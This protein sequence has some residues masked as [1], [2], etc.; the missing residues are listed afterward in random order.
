MSG[1]I[2]G[3]HPVKGASRRNVDDSVAAEVGSDY[4]LM[5]ASTADVTTVTSTEGVYRYVSPACQR[6]FGWDPAE[7]VGRYQSWFVHPEDVSSLHT[8]WGHLSTGQVSTATY[9]FRQ[10]DGSYRWTETTSRQIRVSGT[11]VVV[12]TVR[13]THERQRSM[14]ALHRQAMTDPLT[15]VVNRTVLM[16]RLSQGVRRLE[17][18]SGQLAVL[19]VDLDRFKALNDSYGHR[20]GDLVLLKMSERFAHHLRPA[21]TLA[22]LGGDEFVIVVEGLAGEEA[23]LELA[24]RI[25]EAGHQAF[26]VGDQE[27]RCTLSIGIACTANRTRTAA[28]LLEEADLALYRAKDRGRD[29]A[30]VF[31]EELRTQAISRMVTEQML[32]R[33]IDE[34]RLVVEYQPVVDLRTGRAVG[35]EALVRIHD[36]ERGLLGPDSFIEVAE[37]TGLLITM[38]EQV[39]TEAVGEA[40]AWRSR[41]GAGEFR[42]VAVNVTGRH[43]ADAQFPNT[44]LDCLDAND[45]APDRF[46][47]EVTERVLMEASRSAMRGL[48]RLREAGVQVGLD[49]FGTGPSSLTCLR[50]FPLDFV[51]LDRTL[52]SGLD[53]GRWELA[54]VSAVVELAHALDLTV[55]AEGVETIR[56]RQVLESIECDRAQGYL[57]ARSS[58][59]E[60]VDAV[61][62]SLAAGR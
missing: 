60:E 2:G 44:V 49:D 27:F 24:R 45:V 31:D 12:S 21:D 59:P 6:L 62:T 47:V 10:R 5:V 22:R 53:H 11:E 42:D 32:R 8:T 57:F 52:V 35:A 48:R 19:Y 3:S 46:Q 58:A 33:A 7:L 43:L 54:A 1:E 25:V 34:E 15:G 16:D 29:R 38:D 55:V 13:D 20:V 50:D 30:E 26:R 56:H 51:K 39:L 14:V 37:E 36:P 9:R 4:E 28:E 18:G 61:V 23:A 40:K 17:R 41:L